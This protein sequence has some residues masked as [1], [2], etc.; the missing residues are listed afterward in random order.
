MFAGKYYEDLSPDLREIV[1]VNHLKIPRRGIK[2]YQ[3]DSKSSSSKGKR[4][5]HSKPAPNRLDIPNKSSSGRKLTKRRDSFHSSNS[6]VE[7]KMSNANFS[8]LDSSF[9][10]THDEILSTYGSGSKK[11]IINNKGNANSKLP[12]IDT[13]SSLQAKNMQK[14]KDVLIRIKEQ[15]TKDLV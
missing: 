6:P 8:D 9:E 15:R 12:D 5:S 13:R 11:K 1:R 14:P 4:S 2:S 10:E 3:Q 7:L